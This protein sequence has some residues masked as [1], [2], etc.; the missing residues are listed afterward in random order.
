MD[1]YIGIDI[2]RDRRERKRV[3]ELQ[4]YV[5]FKIMNFNQYLI[6]TVTKLINFDI[7][8]NMYFPLFLKLCVLS[9]YGDF[10]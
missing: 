3:R 6:Q 2:K 4:K 9:S 10:Y 8:K 1:T 7:F 5:L